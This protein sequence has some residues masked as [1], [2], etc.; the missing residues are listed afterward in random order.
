[1]QSV[2]T[3][4]TYKEGGDH[5]YWCGA[6][7]L[8]QVAE[9]EVARDGAQPGRHQGHGH[10]GGA[11]SGGEQLYSQAVQAVEAHRGDG[12]EDAGE[13]EVH[14]GA[15]DQVDEEGRGSAEQH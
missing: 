14:G 8:H 13:D 12:A 7:G 5:Q 3:G 11:E 2:V 10:G 4:H 6:V 9:H 1:M 15:I